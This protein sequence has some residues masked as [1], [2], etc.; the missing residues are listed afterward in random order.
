MRRMN[1]PLAANRSLTLSRVPE[2]LELKINWSFFPSNFNFSASGT[3]V[4][5][6]FRSRFGKRCRTN[7]FR[8]SCRNNS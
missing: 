8:L 3:L 2:S 5:F 4:T 7:E 6:V 1:G